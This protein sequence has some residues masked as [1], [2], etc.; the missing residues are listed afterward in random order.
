MFSTKITATY[1][2]KKLANSIHSIVS[3]SEG[4]LGRAAES[5]MKR[6]IDE[7]LKPRLSQHTIKGRLEGK[8]WGGLKGS[9]YKTTSITPLKHTGALYDSLTFDEES[10]TINM[11]S[12]GKKHQDG[13]TNPQGK[14]VPARKFMD[15]TEGKK[16]SMLFGLLT[17]KQ[18]DIFGKK[19]SKS[20]RLPI[21]KKLQR[22]FNKR[23]KLF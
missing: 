21:G 8:Y 6:A 7:Q 2:F 4:N 19:T 22:A 3:E 17:S 13:F 1:S 15:I 16:E 10:K 9:K 12:Y 18:P 5:I 20:S 14:E 11:L 23:G